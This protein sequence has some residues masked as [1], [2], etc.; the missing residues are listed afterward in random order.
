MFSEKKINNVV[1]KPLVNAV[2]SDP[3]KV[4]GGNLIPNPYHTTFLCAKRKSG[5]TSVIAELLKKTTDKK[6][7]FWIF[8]PTTGIDDSWKQILNML[9]KR[10]NQVNTFESIMDGKVNLL[11]E[12]I[13]G[14]LEPVEQIEKKEPTMMPIMGA[15]IKFEPEPSEMKKEYKPK[16]L[17]PAN[18]FV[19][20]DL[21]HEL[22]NTAIYKLL[23]NGRHTKSAVYISFQYPLDILPAGWKNCEFA[24]CFKS[25]SRDK[26][27]HIHKHL[28]LTL[29]I[30]A[31][32]ELYDYIMSHD[33]YDFM[34]IDVRNQNYRR[35]FNREINL[36]I[37]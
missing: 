7:V 26:L 36:S 6:T 8:C 23:K 13:N 22:K 24:L 11:D 10:G 3:T 19:F 5:K 32:Y 33:P 31:F 17:A 4:K 18:V 16:K 9:E 29:D 25:F 14:L 37:E 30:G 1:V 12:I 15:K 28:D 20:D 34:Y 27:E 35:N 2:I 21:S